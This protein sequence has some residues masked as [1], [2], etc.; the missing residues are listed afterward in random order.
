MHL[1]DLRKITVKKH[2]LV[3][4][5]L[6]NGMECVMDEHGVARVP[7]LRAVPGFSLEDE[8]A[9]AQNFVVEPA[10]V[11]EKDKGRVKPRSCSRAEI[12]AMSTVGAGADS[13]HDEHDE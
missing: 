2:L 1:S 13:A 8:L 9:Q 3:R 7:E 4:F 5:R 12:E 6:S 11:S 10:G